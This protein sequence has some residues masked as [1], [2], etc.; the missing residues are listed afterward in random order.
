MKYRTL[1]GERVYDLVKGKCVLEDPDVSNNIRGIVSLKQGPKDKGTSL[2][3]EIWALEYGEYKMTINA[4]GDLRDGCDSAGPVF[5]PDGSQSGYA[6]GKKIVAKAPGVL[7]DPVFGKHGAAIVETTADVDLSGT[8]SVVGRSIVLSRP[9]GKRVACCTIGLA[10][11]RVYK[12]KSASFSYDVSAPAY[13]AAP[14]YDDYDAGYGA[15]Y[16]DGGYGGY[17]A[18]PYDAPYY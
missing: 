2:W 8:Q 1:V 14:L 12:P 4:L 13:K 18:D 5:N 6:Y 9:N 16:G 7:E 3:G 15:G 17:G 10:S 11:D